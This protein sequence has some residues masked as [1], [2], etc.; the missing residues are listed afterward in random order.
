MKRG[1]PSARKYAKNIISRVYKLENLILVDSSA[2]AT[3]ND[4]IGYYHNTIIYSAFEKKDNINYWKSISD[5]ARVLE[6]NK[7][8]IN[9]VPSTSYNDTILN[10]TTQSFGHD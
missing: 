3:I 5:Y 7:E 9:T 10:V 2:T 1:H 8:I 4:S 6:L